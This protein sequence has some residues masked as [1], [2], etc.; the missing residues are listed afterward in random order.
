MQYFGRMRKQTNLPLTKIN[1]LLFFFKILKSLFFWTKFNRFLALVK[2]YLSEIWNRNANFL[3]QVFFVLIL[4]FPVHLAKAQS[5]KQDSLALE[6]YNAKYEQF[7]DSLEYKAKQK[8]LTRIIYDFLVAPPRPYVDREALSKE[9]YG[10][11]EGKIISE[12]SIQPLE[13]FGP[14]FED[15]S[16]T[17]KSWLEKTANTIHSKSNLNTI[18]K[19]LFFDV[20]DFVDPELLYEN[21]RIIRSLPYIQDV[22]IVLEQ[23][24]V[25]KGLVKVH[26]LTKDRF[27]IGVSGEVD[28]GRSA[29]LQLY[30]QNIF[31]VGH[32]ISFNFVGHLNR[33]P[34]T[35]LETFYKIKNIKGKFI[36]IS[37]GYMNTYK[38]E[39]FSLIL[40]KPFITPSVKWGLGGSALRMYRT[41]RINETH[42]IQ[43]SIPMDLAF[44]NAWAGRSFQIKPDHF[45][46]S[47]IIVSAGINNR[48]YFHRPSPS[49]D[50]L[51]Y[52]SN[53]TFY[54]AGIS[55]SQRRYLQDQLIYSY[56]VTEDIP[57]GFKNEIVYGFDAN[58]FGNRHYAHLF[59]SNGNLLV[60]KQGYLYLSGGI[61][62]FFKDNE[63]EQGQIQ[64]S[65]N[66]ISK[67]VHAGRK[68]FRLFVRANYL[69]G[70]R[71]FEIENL[72]LNRNDHI[73]GF[74]SHLAMG[75]QRLSVDLEYVLFL[76]QQ[77]YKFNMAV[78]GFADVGIIGSNKTLI[79]TENYYSGLGFGMRIHNENLVFKTIH[80]R[81]GFYPFHPSDMGFAGFI[82][83]EQLKKVFYSFQPTAPQPLRFE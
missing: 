28:G 79:F 59:L 47:Q 21:E 50:G 36:D 9:Y 63:Y 26:V 60:N 77:F 58:E 41:D 24:S 76:R 52:F 70:I 11:M 71:R 81:L 68:R 39:G 10:Q 20:G 12:I 72:T 22:R 27:S 54:L 67:Q 13:V 51:Q 80:L 62:G 53:S 82:L 66:F 69:L 35:G 33:Q 7:Y 25:Y 3:A 75:K 1:S 29:A 15:T 61:G 34:Y 64:G 8:T 49:D 16:R 5:N 31:G 2:T 56:G 57:E 37:G 73:R 19:M 14:T 30:N 65:L 44:F 18:E 48:T 17:A 46:N 74:R 32:E 43:T 42:P 55:F 4:L 38:R 45:Q 83:E 78:Y 40:D 23:D 6:K